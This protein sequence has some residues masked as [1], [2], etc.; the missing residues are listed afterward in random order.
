MIKEPPS[1]IKTP[2]IKIT[3]L[4]S[5]SYFKKLSGFFAILRQN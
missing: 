5:K 4:K 2:T 3:Y 1:Y